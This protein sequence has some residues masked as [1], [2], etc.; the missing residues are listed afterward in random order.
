MQRFDIL[1]TELNIFQNTF[2][3]A[4]AGTGKTFAIEH[5][6]V[7]LLMESEKPIELK[8]ILAVTFTKEAAHE[9]K[10]R[11]RK[12]LETLLPE[13][14]PRVREALVN[15]DEIQVFTIHG[16]CHRML[17]EFAFEAGAPVALSE[18]AQE[19]HQVV[20]DFFRTGSAEYA[21]AV[22]DVMK[23]CR[24]DVD[25]AIGKIVAAMEKNDPDPMV[26]ECRARWLV[27][28]ARSDHFTFDDLLRKMEIALEAEPFLEKVRAKYKAVIVDEFQ[29]TD[30]VQWRIFDKLF[31]RSHLIY[32]VGDPKQSIYG[33][34][35]ADIY[36]YMRA[37]ECIGA[38]NKRYLDTNFRSSPPLIEKL[39]SLFIERPD[40][41]S[42]PSLP[43]A[44]QYHPVKAG[45][46]ETKWG[47]DPIHYFGARGVQGRERSWPTKKMEEEKLFPFISSEI[48]RLQ[49]EIKFSEMVVLIKD[50]FQAG[51]LQLHLNQWK[52]PSLIKQTF[53]L[54]ESRGFKTM[55]M[56]LKAAD[57][58]L[59]EEKGFALFFA[60]FKGDP[61]LYLELRQTAE[62]LMEQGF[63]GIEEHL[64]LMQELKKSN[65]ETDERLKL[66][67]E[68]GEDKVAIMTTFAS[69]GLEFDVVFALGLASRHQAEEIDADREAEKMRQLYVAFTRS[70]EKLYIPILYDEAQ[71]PIPPGSG[72][73]IELFFAGRE[74]PTQWIGNIPIVPYVDEKKAIELTPPP[75]VELHFEPEYLTSFTAMSKSQG[76]GVLAYETQDFSKKT[77]HTLPLGAE[78]GVVLHTIFENHF[79]D[80]TIPLEEI[81][82]ETL[83]GTHLEGWE[84]VIEKMV[85]DTL[86]MPLIGDFSLNKLKEGEYFQEMEF[87]FPQENQLIKG[88]I[89]LVFVKDDRFY[90]VDW[91][92]NWL[93]PTEA[94]YT[95]EKLHTAMLEHDYYLQAQLYR[96]AVQRY[97]KRLD[98]GGIYYIFVRGKK[99]VHIG[100]C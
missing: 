9:M 50:R 59:F 90:I 17:T 76:H 61:A 53:N 40:W 94:D 8:E 7:R 92:T 22:A 35:S 2:L 82:L 31:V 30:P 33:F 69:K 34:R 60:E 44:L 78:T 15:F 46:T 16:F 4:S 10:S 47:E 58:Q 39:N 77:A 67:G 55:E 84:E 91:K 88:F 25:K 1:D 63:V 80:R 36:T 96:E 56:L 81:I 83:I 86:S 75:K 48:L 98:F 95:D 28:A 19:M 29:D 23:K 26:Q 18:P 24:Y 64:H 70:R 5:L 21:E 66:R 54:V 14:N 49:K 62:I 87:L 11:I 89:D 52:I 43:G 12:K 38:A 27:K 57:K 99:E 93:G 13:N 71:K 41:I 85:Q 68:Q 73:P 6:V 97:V 42:L 37:A 3:E 74:V 45:R 100:N 72:S 51:R 32:L 79:Q 20:A 65:P